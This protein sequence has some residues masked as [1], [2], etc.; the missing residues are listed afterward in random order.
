MYLDYRHLGRTFGCMSEEER[1]CVDEAAEKFM[2]NC[3]ESVYSLQKQST[4][5]R[6]SF[7]HT[8]MYIHVRTVYPEILAT[9]LIWR[10]GGQDENRQFISLN[11]HTYV[12]LRTYYALSLLCNGQI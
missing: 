1:D 6:S 10:F 9:F 12:D 11:L 7:M 2:K 5:Y 3:S 4:Y 8:Y